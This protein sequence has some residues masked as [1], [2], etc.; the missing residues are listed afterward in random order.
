MIVDET[1]ASPEGQLFY[2]AALSR[3]PQI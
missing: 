3:R 2:L 1:H